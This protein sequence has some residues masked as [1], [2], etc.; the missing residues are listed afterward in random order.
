MQTAHL[1]AVTMGYGLRNV[2]SIP[3]ALEELRRVLRPGAKAAILDFNN[4]DN[5]LADSFQVHQGRFLA[6][7]H[8]HPLLNREQLK[9]MS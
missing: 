8:P 4:S 7:Q 6:L 2:A 1:D 3:K 5:T 9:A